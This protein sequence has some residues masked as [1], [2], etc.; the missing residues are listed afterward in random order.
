[1]EGENEREAKRAADG[2]PRGYGVDADHER[3]PW[4]TMASGRRFYPQD[5]DHRDVCLDDIAHH[6]AQINRYNGGLVRPLSVAE[7][8]IACAALAWQMGCDA[9]IQFLALMHDAAEA[10]VGDMVRP[11][12]VD[13]LMYCQAEEQV[14]DMAIARRFALPLH[15][16]MPPVVSEIDRIICATEKRD[17]HPNAEPWPNMPDPDPDIHFQ[18][19]PPAWPTMR[20][21]FRQVAVQLM[22]QT[23]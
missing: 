7:H 3:G 19:Q 22:E 18:Q 2:H 17:L 23:T 9:E 21:H 1:M 14:W 13:M 16:D 15:R 12:K 10:Y 20:R 4:M 11:L 6:L 5:P 8:S